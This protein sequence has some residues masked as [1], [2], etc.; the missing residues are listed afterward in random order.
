MIWKYNDTVVG[1]STAAVYDDILDITHNIVLKN[2]EFI[3]VIPAVTMRQNMMSSYLFDKDISRDYGHMSLGLG[4][5]ALGLLWYCYLTGGSA[6]D[7]SFIPKESDVSPALLE[8]F[9]FDEITEKKARY[10]L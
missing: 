7:V 4:R 6:E 10:S 2:P 9:T 5:Y 8:K 3:G 1:E